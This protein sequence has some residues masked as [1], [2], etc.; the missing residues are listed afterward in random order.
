MAA[1]ASATASKHIKCWH[2]ECASQV[3]ATKRCGACGT[4]IYCAPLCQEKDWGMHKV[5]CLSFQISRDPLNFAKHFI[6]TDQFDKL[7]DCFEKMV[8]DEQIKYVSVVADSGKGEQISFAMIRNQLSFGILVNALKKEVQS[9]IPVAARRSVL[10][11]NVTVAASHVSGMTPTD[12]ESFLKE[13][14]T[15]A[16]WKT[17]DVAIVLFKTGL[18]QAAM[19]I[20][21]G[22]PGQRTQFLQAIAT[23]K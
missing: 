4:A 15:N 3:S 7:D 14:S 5:E 20:M 2:D 13:M 21:K 1:V 23:K 11:G 10:E 22:L 18:Q 8:T 16:A 17:V 19:Q 12:Q 9:K 6:E